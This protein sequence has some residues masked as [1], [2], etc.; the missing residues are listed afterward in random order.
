MKEAKEA[1]LG[2]GVSFYSQAVNEAE[3]IEEAN[4]VVQAQGDISSNAIDF[5]I[6]LI[7]PHGK[8]IGIIRHIAFLGKPDVITGKLGQIQFP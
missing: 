5:R 8:F 1:G 6:L 4:L 7:F 2:I 3:A